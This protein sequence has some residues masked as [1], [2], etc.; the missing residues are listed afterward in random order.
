MPICS[1]RKPQQPPDV[2]EIAHREL[3]V[4]PPDGRQR[5]VVVNV[6]CFCEPEEHRMDVVSWLQN[7]GLERYASAFRDNDIDAEVLPKLTAEDLISIGV[8]S[9]GAVLGREF[10]YA[11]IE[12]VARRPE[13]E[14]RAALGQLS[15]AGLLFCRGTA[16][17]ASYL[18]KHA[19]VQ[20]AA[21]GTLLRGRRQ[22][23]H[24]RVAAASEAHFADLLE[25]QPELLAHH[26]TAAGDT[27]VNRADGR[28]PS[29][30]SRRVTAGSRKA[31]TPPI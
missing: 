22:E 25:R 12:T 30:C 8:T 31:S 2:G 16:P 5:Y 18:F 28:K 19:L 24:G 13:K 11:L 3:I 10:S 7:L 9:V 20:D 29:I 27:G 15:D 26:L 1:G 23:L 6:C 4:L 14:L 17:H 21:Y